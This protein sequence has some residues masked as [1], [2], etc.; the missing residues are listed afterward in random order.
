[1]FTR[2][3]RAP[4][5]FT[6]SSN[7]LRMAAS[8]ASRAR[9]GPLA[10]PVPIIAMP[11]SLITV[12]TSAK[13]TLI[14][15]GRLM[16]SEIPR[17]APASTSSALANADSRLASLPRMV[18][19]FSFGIV[20]NESTLS[21]SRR[22]PSSAICMRLR[23]SNGNGRVTTATVRMPISLATSAM[24]GAAPVPV[25]PPMPVVMNTMLVPC[26]TS[27]MRSRSSRAA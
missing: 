7:G 25:P 6:S 21:D 27:A 22:I 18:S 1:M 2:M 17:T 3:P 9:F 20:I 26:N 19:S 24:I 16:M 5:R 4:S 23:P 14:M 12:R 8:V 15:P 13:S 11:I 10:Q